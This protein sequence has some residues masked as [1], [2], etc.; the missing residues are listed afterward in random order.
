MS[1]ATR[2]D[3]YLFSEHGP[4]HRGPVALV[5][6][7]VE[8]RATASSS[9]RPPCTEVRLRHICRVEHP[10]HGRAGRAAAQPLRR[11]SLPDKE[12]NGSQCPL[13]GSMHPRAMFQCERDEDRDEQIILVL[14]PAPCRQISVDRIQGGREPRAF[15]RHAAQP[16]TESR[17]RRRLA[18]HTPSRPSPPPTANAF[19]PGLNQGLRHDRRVDLSAVRAFVPGKTP[20][21]EGIHVPRCRKSGPMGQEAFR[22]TM[23][24]SACGRGWVRPMSIIYCACAGNVRARR[25]HPRPGP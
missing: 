10:P 14:R 16:S 8:I 21:P 22:P 6:S 18:K 13:Q 24:A 5:R 7:F 9:D 4:Y 1:G 3:T 20:V 2:V 25:R 23:R 15:A 11:E 17:C 12:R 19:I